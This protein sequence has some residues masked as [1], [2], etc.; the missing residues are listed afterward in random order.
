MNN[1]YNPILE[2]YESASVLRQEGYTNLQI[3]NFIF[4]ACC[5]L[6]KDVDY[7]I[8]YEV[9]NE[10][11]GGDPDFLDYISKSL[12]GILDSGGNAIK[13][14]VI[15]L[16]MDSMGINQGPVRIAIS[17]TVQ[18]LGFDDL[19]AFTSGDNNRICAQVFTVIS[20]VVARTVLET[21]GH[22]KLGLDPDGIIYNMLMQAFVPSDSTKGMP[23]ALN[24]Y[25]MKE[26]CPKI[27]EQLNNMNPSKWF[28]GT[29]SEF[30]KNWNDNYKPLDFPKADLSESQKL[31]IEN[32]QKR[33]KRRLRKQMSRLLDGG[34]KDLT[35][36]GGAFT[37][38]RQK[39]SNAY[40]AK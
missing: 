39:Y 30:M 25:M 6:E 35:K 21:A 31:Q 14:V 18:D 12:G 9:L 38:P 22:E 11:Q 2:I 29:G 4:E 3:S 23:G 8:E 19:R 36:F 27:S 34:R 15:G 37:K 13:R 32:F 20:K 1:E 33:M 16:V 17:N 10:E 26:V 28:S 7:I 24:R 40:V 5:E